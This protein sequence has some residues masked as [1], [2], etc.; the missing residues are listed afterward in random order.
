M[1]SII[2]QNNSLVDTL[3]RRNMGY[4]VFTGSTGSLKSQ[5]LCVLPIEL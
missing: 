1:T 4:E 2:D 3:W 5:Y